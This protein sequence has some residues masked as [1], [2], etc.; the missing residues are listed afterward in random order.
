VTS[1]ILSPAVLFGITQ[2]QALVFL[3]VVLPFLV[4]VPVIY[5]VGWRWKGKP[6]PI[7]T[8]AILEHGDPAH[9]TVLAIKP[10]GGFLDSRPMIRFSLRVTAGGGE[11]PFD[12]EVTQSM[13]RAVSREIRVGETI[14]VRVTPDHS[15]GAVV[16]SE[17]GMGD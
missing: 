5:F 14:D 8:S 11:E 15:A 16:W 4:A 3:F 2:D 7:R 12:L 9:A 17:I 10:L 13:P 1:S 6:A